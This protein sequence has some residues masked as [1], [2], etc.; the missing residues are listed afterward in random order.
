[1]IF[2]AKIQK[3]LYISKKSC[4][5]A[6]YYVRKRKINYLLYEKDCISLY[7][8]E[9]VSRRKRCFRALW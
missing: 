9:Y 4:T 5:F 2:A 8:A 1:M 7:C 3:N 6:R